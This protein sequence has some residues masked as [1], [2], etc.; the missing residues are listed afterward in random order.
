MA[1]A[2]AAAIARGVPSLAAFD[3]SP[4]RIPTPELRPRVSIGIGTP[5][6]KLGEG[7]ILDYLRQF[8]GDPTTIREGKT[9]AGTSV[10]HVKHRL[11]QSDDE[12]SAVYVFPYEGPDPEEVRLNAWF[13]D[14]PPPE[15]WLGAILNRGKQGEPYNGLIT[16]TPA[17]ADEWEPII[18]QYPEL[19][20]WINSRGRASIQSSV[21]D[22]RFLHVPGCPGYDRGAGFCSCTCP[23]IV[24]QEMNNE[25]LADARARL[26]GEHVNIVGGCPWTPDLLKRWFD[27]CRDPLDVI[28]FAVQAERDG[29]AGMDAVELIVSL[30]VWRY[31]ENND[32]CIVI[33]DPGRG[34]DDGIHDPDGLHVR[35]RL[36]PGRAL[37]ARANQYLGPWGLGM[38]AVEAAKTY[39]NAPIYVARGG[40][41]G[42]AVLSAIRVSGYRNVAPDLVASRIKQTRQQLGVSE[43]TETRIMAMNAVTA[44]LQRGQVDLPSHDVVTCFKNCIKDR[45]GKIVARTGWHD[46]DLV[47]T[48]HGNRLLDLL[49]PPMIFD[50]HPR[51]SGDDFREQL[52]REGWRNVRPPRSGWRGPRDIA[53]W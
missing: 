47:L 1:A 34:I 15:S 3:G 5:S 2:L 14:G 46:E 53:K 29:S 40:G 45:N 17:K 35:S 30:Q 36:E 42:E 9:S 28:E 25:G 41:Y 23:D 13:A 49:G 51:L 26:F 27:R 44:M 52:E 24:R 16:A 37:V 4:I 22:N 18:K 31:P 33:A 6:Y 43:T 8:L 20:Q 32:P 19:T 21:Y 48:G 12:W 39:G 7:S 10:F 50:T 38:A 11:S